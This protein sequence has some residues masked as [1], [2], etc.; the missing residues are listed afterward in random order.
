MK[1]AEKPAMARRVGDEALKAKTGKAWKEWFA[2]LDKAGAK[3]MN[4]T[5]IATVVHDKFGCPGWWSQM[6]AVGYEQARNMR[7]KHQKPEGYEISV[8]KTVAASVGAAFKA[9][10]DEKTRHRWL[11]KT[12]IVIHKATPPKSMRVTWTD[13]QKS[14]SV[15]FYPKG[16]G[17]SQVVLQHGKLPDAKAAERMKSYWAGALGRLQ[18]IFEG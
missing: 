17:K 9:W 6:V 7:E 14:I 12:A 8:S 18:G 4:H 11:P 3:K 15:N 13:G 16:T 5:E 2:I 1:K 10:Q